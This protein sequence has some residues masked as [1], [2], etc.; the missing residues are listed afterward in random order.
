VGG[1]KSGFKAFGRLLCSRP[2]A[3][4]LFSFSVVHDE[5]SFRPN[6]RLKQFS[7]YHYAITTFATLALAI[8][9]YNTCTFGR[10]FS[11][12]MCPFIPPQRIRTPGRSRRS[13]ALA[14]MQ[15]G[16]DLIECQTLLTRSVARLFV[17]AF[18]VRK[19]ACMHGC[20]GLIQCC[21][22]SIR[23]LCRPARHHN[24]SQC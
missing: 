9:C 21:K 18:R 6:I 4:T 17:Y 24:L 11:S 13:V 5:Y 8:K 19:R 10:I 16:E 12:I 7:L 20:C 22:P 1:A 23:Y 14:L 2:K 15:A 3:K